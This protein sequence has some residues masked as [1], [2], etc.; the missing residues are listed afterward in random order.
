MTDLDIRP[1]GR[2]WGTDELWRHDE[3]PGC[4][5]LVGGRLCMDEAQR[6]A[7]LGAL[8]EHV[9]T[10]RAV[11]VGPLQA[12]MSAVGARQEDENWANTPSVGAEQFWKASAMRMPFRQRLAWKQDLRAYWRTKR[13]GQHKWQ[14]SGRER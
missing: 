8:L 3:L 10:W 1:E 14:R 11:R 13:R 5:E 12:W 7:L 6:L 4:L 9:G 2:C